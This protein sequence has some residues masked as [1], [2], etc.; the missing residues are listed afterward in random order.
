MAGIWTSAI[1]QAVSTRR[2]D[3]RKS[4]ADEGLDAVAQRP[5]EPSHGIAKGWIIL[6]DA[7]FG[8]RQFARTRQAGAPSNNVVAPAREF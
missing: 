6:N 4:A 1:K 8:F 2:G 7:T 5:H 3:A